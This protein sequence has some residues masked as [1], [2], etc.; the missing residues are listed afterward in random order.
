MT[1]VILLALAGGSVAVYLARRPWRFTKIEEGA[2]GRAVIAA[3]L[4]AS[5][6]R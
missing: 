2:A 3:N 6:R 5:R 1:T 4:A